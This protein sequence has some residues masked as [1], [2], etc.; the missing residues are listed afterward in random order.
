MKIF[1]F[2][3]KFQSCEKKK[4]VDI[5]SNKELI[6]APSI[7]YIRELLV[8]FPSFSQN[9]KKEELLKV[10]LQSYLTFHENDNTI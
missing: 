6:S 8:T 5:A 1:S 9:N 3:I 2:E 4:K 10:S 7:M